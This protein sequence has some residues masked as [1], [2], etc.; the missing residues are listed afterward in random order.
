[1]RK[2]KNS[3][4]DRLSVEDF[5]EKVKTPLIIVLDNIRSLNNIG[6]VFRTSDAFLIEKIYLCGITAI[7]PHKDI[8]KTALGSTETV[9]WE[10]VENT[11]E[12]V[13]NLK[14][15]NIKIVSIEQAENA[16]MLNDF[17]PQQKTKYAL[18]FGNEVKGVA[19]NIVSNSDVVLEIPQFGT[20]HS[21]NI[22][23]SCGVVVWDL[24][25]KLTANSK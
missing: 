20:K 15:D 5:K 6:S 1:M 2:L 25:S 18:V 24:F 13:E 22:S 21:L 16:T 9:A 8:H 7:P 3:E 23:V 17:K 12:L 4:L 10:Y 19:Q 14:K 11:L